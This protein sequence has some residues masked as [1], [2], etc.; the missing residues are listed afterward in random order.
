MIEAGERFGDELRLVVYLEEAPS[1]DAEKRFIEKIYEF[2]SVEKID[3][4]SPDQAFDR[5]SRQLGKEKD[6]LADLT[7]AFLPYSIEIYPHQDLKNLTRIKTFSDYLS[8]LP[9]VAKVQYGH[10]WIE[11]FGNFINLLRLIVFLSGTLLIFTT[12][13]MVSYTIRLTLVA[14]HQE[15]KVLR[16]LGATNWYIK[17][18][19]LIEGFLLGLIGSVVGIISLFIIFQW[20]Q[21]RFE[22]PGLISLFQLSFL[23][24]S[25][26][27]II[28]VGSIILCTS[29]SLISIRKL[30]RI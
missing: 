26:T 17:G 18:P 5:L 12:I 7:S 13:F 22:G 16:Y 21:A 25:H 20:I 27:V 30:L 3:F 2:S 29:G 28:L 9:G 19:V 10:G 8:L 6:V 15:L 24:F 11:R 23:P 4:I 1:K 14:R